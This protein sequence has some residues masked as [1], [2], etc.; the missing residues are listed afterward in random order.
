MIYEKRELLWDVASCMVLSRHI[1]CLT[2]AAIQIHLKSLSAR[3][4]K[5]YI[6]TPVIGLAESISAIEFNFLYVRPR[7]I[8]RQ[9]CDQIV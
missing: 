3:K 6:V 5:I 1:M 4:V 8:V 9:K 2:V 7:L